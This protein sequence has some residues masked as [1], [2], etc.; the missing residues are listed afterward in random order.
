ME[1]DAGAPAVLLEDGTHDLRGGARVARRLEQHHRAGAQ[2]RRD[3]LGRV[4]HER[5]V[6]CLGGVEGSR[7]AEEHRLGFA[8]H[9]RIGGG[10]QLPRC[11]RGG[12]GVVG[13]VVDMAATVGER[14]DARDVDVEGDRAEAGLR[15]RQREREPDVPEADVADDQ[16][17]RRKPL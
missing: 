6:G 16:L 14:L 9:V 13:D 15:V 11:E 5:Q 2:Q 8:Q 3:R 17:A 1:V 7:H 12:D 4:P 10:P